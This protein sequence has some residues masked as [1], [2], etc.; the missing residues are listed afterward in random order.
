MSEKENKQV[1]IRKVFLT[2]S[3]F[4]YLLLFIFFFYFKSANVIAGNLT[5]S[6]IISDTNYIRAKYNLYPLKE[7][8]E[9]TAAAYLKAYDMFNDQYWDHISPDGKTPWYFI[10]NTN[11]DFRFAG[12]NLAKDFSSSEDV[13]AAW[14]ESPDHRANILNPNYEDIGV[15]IVQG[16][17]N[18]K[19]TILI[20]A[21][22][23]AEYRTQNKTSENNMHSKKIAI[24]Y[25]LDSE[26]VNDTGLTILGTV[27]CFQDLKKLLIYDNGLKI[28][29]VRLKSDNWFFQ[30]E[31]SFAE[32]KHHLVVYKANDVKV[33]DE[34]TFWI[35]SLPPTIN[36]DDINI[37]RRSIGY[38]LS[39]KVQG[40]ADNVMVLFNNNVFHVVER[41]NGEY[42][43]TLPF[44]DKISEVLILVSDKNNNVFII[45]VSDM[46]KPVNSRISLL[47]GNIL[48]FFYRIKLVYVIIF[49]VLLFIFVIDIMLYRKYQLVKYFGQDLLLLFAIFTFFLIEVVTQFVGGII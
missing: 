17:L 25:P 31:R 20:V 46:I 26:T 3:L 9:L 38:N 12:E 29:E 18:G 13:I 10:R 47:L 37:K 41:E 16:R 32:G 48:M 8:A 42:S 5:S 33:F 14:M 28:G 1:R 7:N 24:R 4:V 27:C 36:G 22:Y 6:A 21:I 34:I 45:N 39:F 23:G 15:A 35:K 43:V 19:K 11:Y 2:L 44:A 40:D 49:L 30:P